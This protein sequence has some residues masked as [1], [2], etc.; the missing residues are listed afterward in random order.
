M[1]AHPR[2]RPRPLRAEAEPL[3]KRALAIHEKA[4]GS[5]YA[6]AEMSL[7]NLALVNMV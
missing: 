2:H 1:A 5:E 3:Y 4:L 6:R 7:N